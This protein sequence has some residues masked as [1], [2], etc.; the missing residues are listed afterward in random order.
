VWVSIPGSIWV[1]VIMGLY[2]YLAHCSYV[3]VLA[4]GFHLLLRC[5]HGDQRSL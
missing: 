3:V 2:I 4:L 5:K 1:T